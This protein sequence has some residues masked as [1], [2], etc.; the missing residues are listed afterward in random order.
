MGSDRANSQ[1]GYVMMNVLF[2]R[3]HNRVAR[4]LAQR[5]PEWADDDE[6]LFQTTRNILIVMLIRIVIEEYINHIDPA[7][8][9]FILDAS[10]FPN[11]RW[12]RQNWMAL[13]F[14]L[15]YRWHGLIPST[16]V[17]DGIELPVEESLFATHL[18]TERG[19]GASLEAASRQR[20]G[21]IGLYNTTNILLSTEV[22]SITQGRQLQLASYN[23][24]REYCQFPRATAFDQISG[25]PEVQ[26]GLENLYGNVD[27]LDYYVGIF[28]EDTRPNSILPALMGRLVAIDA[29]SQAL[30]N[31]LLA[32]NIFNERTFSPMGLEM[33][34]QTSTLSALAL[35]NLPDTPEPRFISMTREGWTRS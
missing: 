32:P 10:A 11:E 8:F 1:I 20:G 12:Y 29:F 21:R 24:Y 15:L 6:R 31:P 17:L 19:L 28:A 3:E 35:R 27:R 23:D 13:E 2:L 30:T 5:Y 25:D 7:Y 18:V 33:I 9:K 14:N 16:L 34:E 26:R 22:A 4:L